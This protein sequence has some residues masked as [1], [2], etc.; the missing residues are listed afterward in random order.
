MKN[1]LV[2]KYLGDTPQGLSPLKGTDSPSLGLQQGFLQEAYLPSEQTPNFL[3]MM[4]GSQFA[5]PSLGAIPELKNQ[6]LKIPDPQS[7]APMGAQQYLTGYIPQ[8]GP[9]ASIGVGL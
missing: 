7:F 9:T 2:E 5:N 6:G 3:D 1:K 8:G 4:M